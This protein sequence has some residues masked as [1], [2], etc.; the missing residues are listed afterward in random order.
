MSVLIGFMPPLFLIVHALTF[1]ETLL[2]LFAGVVLGVLIGLER[3]WRSRTAGVHTSGLV[4]A[5]GALFCLAAPALGETAGDPMR[6]L[7][8]VAQ[9]VG[10]LAG[11][12]ILKQ[13]MSVSGL[14]TAATIWAT[15]AV[16]ALAGVGLIR[17]AAM[18]AVT[19]VGVNLIFNPI[20][21]AINRFTAKHPPKET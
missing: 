21:D 6:A 2:R 3:E 17:E 20:V 19:I 12:V 1:N 5:G 16:G 4:A 13:G 9:G 15:A 18:G 7:A 8:A 14:N 11:G 10:F